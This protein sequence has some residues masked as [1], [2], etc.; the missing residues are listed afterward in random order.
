MYCFISR[1]IA[2]P[3]SRSKLLQA[4]NLKDLSSIAGQFHLE[5]VH[6]SDVRDNQPDKYL[7]PRKTKRQITN[8]HLFRQRNYVALIKIYHSVNIDLA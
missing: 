5:K 2:V 8:L 1:L 3:L 7:E 4:K 6:P